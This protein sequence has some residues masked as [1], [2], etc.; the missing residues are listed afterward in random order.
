MTFA[1]PHNLQNRL[2]QN[3][4]T[5]SLMS[6]LRPCNVTQP[7]GARNLLTVAIVWGAV[8][9]FSRGKIAGALRRIP[10]TPALQ[11][12]LTESGPN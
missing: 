4:M 12:W 8:V 2:A 10:T 3:R 5:S 9:S 11:W 7:M 6:Q 1:L